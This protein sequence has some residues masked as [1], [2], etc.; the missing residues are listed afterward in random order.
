MKCADD[1]RL[2][3]AGG[4]GPTLMRLLGV[5]MLAAT[6]A[7]GV[8]LPVKLYTTADGLVSNRVGPVFSDSR[9]FLWFGTEDGL[10]RF[11]GSRFVNFGTEQG[12]PYPVVTWIFEVRDGI[13]W[14]ATNDGIARLD[15]TGNRLGNLPGSMTNNAGSNGAGFGT[16]VNDAGTKRTGSSP[17]DPNRAGFVF[18]KFMVSPDAAPNRINVL[19][20]DRAGTLWLGTDGGVFTLNEAEGKVTFQR[21]QLSLAQPDLLIQTWCLLEDEEGSMWI[22]TKFGLVRRLPNGRTVQYSTKSNLSPG[23]VF[24]VIKDR[25]GILWVAHSM[26]LSLFRPGSAKDPGA[27]GFSGGRAP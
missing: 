11:D 10:S 14:V 21:V 4:A 6:S 3:Q 13:F 22:G 2:A 7:P 25:S 26:G 15:A 24:S 12:L 1:R 19:Y 23:A 20:R 27:L 9:G 17:T 5:A 8:E 16:R 18:E